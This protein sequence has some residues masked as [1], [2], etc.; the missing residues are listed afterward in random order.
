MM[1]MVMTMMMMIIMIIIAFTHIDKVAAAALLHASNHT[2]LQANESIE[3]Y[4]YRQIRVHERFT[5]L[6]IAE[7]VHDSAH[8]LFR[9][10]LDAKMYNYFHE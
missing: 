1:M 2:M 9:F 5:G 6:S 8:R 7:P 3:F 4:F 10:Q